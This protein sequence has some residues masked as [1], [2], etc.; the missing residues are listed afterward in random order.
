MITRNLF[1][2]TRVVASAACEVNGADAK[3]RPAI[4]AMKHF[5]QFVFM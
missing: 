5:L 1:G 4:A 2:G 3:T